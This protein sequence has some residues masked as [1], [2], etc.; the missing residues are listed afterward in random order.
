MRL[1]RLKQVTRPF[2]SKSKLAGLWLFVVPSSLTELAVAIYWYSGFILWP[3]MIFY[4]FEIIFRRPKLACSL[5]PFLKSLVGLSLWG[6]IRS[7]SIFV[8]VAADF[9]YGV[10]LCP[11]EKSDQSWFDWFASVFTK[12]P[13]VNLSCASSICQ[14][15]L[16]EPLLPKLTEEAKSALPFNFSFIPASFMR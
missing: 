11:A 4:I 13:F 2:G 5:S 16:V 12:F 3:S 7:W 1:R 14:T 6:A 9:I 10:I 15:A 8:N